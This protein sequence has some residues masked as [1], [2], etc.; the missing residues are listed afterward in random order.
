MTELVTAETQTFFEYIG[1]KG[2]KLPNGYW[3]NKKNQKEYMEWIKQKLGYTT[4][5]DWYKISWKYLLNNNGSGILKNYNGSPIQLVTSIYPNYNWSTWKFHQ[6]PRGYWKDIKHQK[7]YMDWLGKKLGYTMMDDWYKINQKDI[8]NNY[9]NGLLTTHYNGSPYNMFM[10]IYPNYNWL[11][12]KFK[13]VPKN[14]WQN[15]KNQKE[16]MEWLGK[17]LGY[18][19]MDDW[20]KITCEDIINNYGSTL[21]SGY[22][23]SSPIKLVIEMYPNYNWFI[24]K[25][26]KGPQSYWKDENNVKEYMEWLKLELGY[27]TMDDWYKITQKDIINN[28]GRN[29]FRYYTINKLVPSIYPNHNWLIWK[30]AFQLKN[31]WKNK[32]N[33]KEYMEWLGKELGY[34]TMDDW[35]KITCEDIINNYGST[36]LNGYYNSSPSKLVIET[37]PNDNWLIWKFQ[38]RPNG[39]WKDENNVK[40]Y[41]EWLKQKLGYTTMDDW[42]KINQKDIYNNYGGGLLTHYYNGSPSK[43]VIEMYPNYKWEIGKFNYNKT[44]GLIHDLLLNNKCDLEIKNIIVQYV[45][46]W[47]DKNYRYDFYI[48]LTNGKK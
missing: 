45:P 19:T 6:V 17:E 39:Y 44:E 3:Q 11:V 26:H 22:Y 33:Q 36:L 23:N 40:E 7:D 1:F 42:Y 31:E 32:K 43:L 30:F 15:K 14:Y 35:Y 38:K 2:K 25:F 41:M 29:L 48:E 34:T 16:Y 12:W 5:E 20:Y 8:Y 37:Y 27:T 28:Y 24:W 10:T 46:K 4:I 47:K 21:L 13:C 9:G 18:T